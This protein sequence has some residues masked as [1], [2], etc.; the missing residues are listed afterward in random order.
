MQSHRQ[1][2]GPEA[3]A[4]CQLEDYLRD[5]STGRADSDEELSLD[6]SARS[7]LFSFRET[8]DRKPRLSVRRAGWGFPCSSLGTPLLT[9]A[10]AAAGSDRAGRHLAGAPQERWPALPP[11]RPGRADAGAPAAAG[12]VQTR[13]PG[14]PGL[15]GEAAHAGAHQGAA[16]AWLNWPAAPAGRQRSPCSQCWPVSA[17]PQP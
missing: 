11:H 1:L 8:S 9:G 10:C 14:Q 6:D 15:R 7:Y 17:A 16:R 3:V 4:L 13:A 2:S 5:Q 12:V